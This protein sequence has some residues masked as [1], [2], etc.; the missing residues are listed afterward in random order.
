MER[1]GSHGV[2]AVRWLKNYRFM[3]EARPWYRFYRN[4]RWRWEAPPAATPVPLLA[5]TPLMACS[6]ARSCFS[7]LGVVFSFRRFCDSLC[8]SRREFSSR[9]IRAE[10]LLRKPERQRPSGEWI[11]CQAEFDLP[12]G[13]NEYNDYVTIVMFLGRKTGFVRSSY[14]TGTERHVSLQAGHQRDNQPNLTKRMV[15][16]KKVTASGHFWERREK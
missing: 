1:C 8:I 14:S 12:R 4:C 5:A 7:G 11:T 16:F 6:R 3:S 10:Y 2:L 13:E 15:N 9:E